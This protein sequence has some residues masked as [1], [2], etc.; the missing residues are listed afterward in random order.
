[1][2]TPLVSV[3]V[4]AFNAERFIAEAVTSILAQTWRNV[5]CLVVDDG[6]RDGTPKLVEEIIS[7][8]EPRLRL[9]RGANTGVAA[10]RNRGVAASN[11]DFVAFLDADDLWLPR[12]LERQIDVMRA[13]PSLGAVYTGLHLIDEYGWF[14]GRMRPP[15]RAE[16][17]RNT[18]LLKRPYVSIITALIPR[19][20][21]DD[22]G[23]FDE[24]LS[25][26]AD[27]DLACRLMLRHEVDCV[28]LCLLLW[29]QHG[30]SQ[31]HRNPRTTEH[32]MLIAYQ[33]LLA[34][35]RLPPDIRREKGYA[36]GNLTVSLAGSYL[37][38]GD[39]R[40][41]LRYAARAIARHPGRV[42][43][44]LDRLTRNGGPE[45]FDA[46]GGGT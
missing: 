13:E 39:R 34:D 14:I 37:H 42:L 20:I 10:A 28:P 15:G 12:K 30:D 24:R 4:P 5:E 22:L 43:G 26:S 27:F 36:M 31:M 25:T 1:M 3:I 11:G 41:F 18:F 40:S 46:P 9:L 16:A 33:K 29:R 23:G 7:R 35:P 8:G 38:K 32:D 6:S 21:F 44:G 45:G 19:A 2:P 17:M